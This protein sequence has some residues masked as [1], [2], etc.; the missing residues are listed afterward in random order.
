MREVY[1][2]GTIVKLKKGQRKLMIIGRVPLMNNNGLIGYFDYAGC[3]IPEGLN[4][5]QSF[6]FNHEDVDQV[7]QRGY[8][9]PEEDEYLRQYEKAMETVQYPRLHLS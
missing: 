7:Y 1:P 2:L 9:G 5:Q 8:E 6:F 3:L 4:G